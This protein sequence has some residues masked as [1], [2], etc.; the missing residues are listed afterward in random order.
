MESFDC[1]CGQ[2]F[3]STDELNEHWKTNNTV[4][5]GRPHYRLITGGSSEDLEG[6][7][8]QTQPREKRKWSTSSRTIEDAI[9]AAEPAAEWLRTHPPG[10]RLPD[11]LEP[12]HEPAEYVPESKGTDEDGE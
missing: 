7:L 9:A 8:A 5:T 4:T 6:I 1:I 3:E 12:G 2:H 11:D 10:A